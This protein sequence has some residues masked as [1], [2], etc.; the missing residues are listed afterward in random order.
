MKTTTTTTTIRAIALLFACSNLN[1]YFARAVGDIKVSYV[2]N[3]D[4]S[5]MVRAF[6]D[7]IDEN[8]G[9]E[10]SKIEVSEIPGFRLGTVAREDVSEGD[11]YL[12][13]PW[14]LV[15]SE[16]S[17]RASERSTEFKKLETDFDF[18]LGQRLLTFLLYEKRKKEASFWKPYIDLLPGSYNV[19]LVW[20]EDDLAELEGTGI[21][22]TVQSWKRDVKKHFEQFRVAMSGTD[23]GQKLLFDQDPVELEE[24]RWASVVLDSRTIWIDGRYQCF[25][26]MLDMVNC[27]DH[28]SKRHHT[29]RDASADATV[30]RAIW[31]TNAGEQLFENYATPN[32]QNLVYHGF[33]LEHNSYDSIDVSL[34][35]VPRVSM[36]RPSLLPLLKSNR[37]RP[38]YALTRQ[39]PFPR[40]LL[41]LARIFALKVGDEETKGARAFNFNSETP[42]NVV[43]EVDAL[44]M[45]ADV[46]DTRLRTAYP[47]SSVEEDR[48]ILD[49]T[50]V[51]ANKRTAVLFR[52]QQKNVSRGAQKSRRE[53]IAIADEE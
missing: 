25:L 3:E 53:K 32:K 37:L 51:R 22:E 23:L 36:D 47:T 43:N 28:P 48:A 19:P 13:I 4:V 16:D 18:D 50:G 1:I 26:P 21:V 15:I 45:I 31:K 42:Y 2:G 7:W 34:P 9:K 14:K 24:F 5:V 30:T 12:S 38:S 52:Y 46:C 17:M 20:S 44:T 41:A 6:N 40:G 10:W 11:I 29:T 8:G 49:D 33:I 39:D 27:M 35:G